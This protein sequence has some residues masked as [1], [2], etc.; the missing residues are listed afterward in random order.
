MPVTLLFWCF[1]PNLNI[2]SEVLPTSILH[3][4]PL[5]LGPFHLG[6]HSFLDPTTSS[7]QSFL[8]VLPPVLA[9]LMV[10]LARISELP[11]G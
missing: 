4:D 10:L 2:S 9:G 6:P 1:L 8:Q 3:L 7:L 11:A 5:Y